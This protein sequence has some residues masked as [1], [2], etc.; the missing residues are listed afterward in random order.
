MHDG[1]R[2]PGSRRALVSAALADGGAAAVIAVA[3]LAPND[4][5]GDLLA[6]LTASRSNALLAAA[7]LEAPAYLVDAL[8]AFKDPVLRRRLVRQAALS[9]EVLTRWLT[10]ANPDQRL[11]AAAA[12]YFRHLTPALVETVLALDASLAEVFAARADLP[13]DV[14]PILMAAFPV[15][16]QWRLARQPQLSAAQV[17]IL[18]DAADEAALAEWVRH[19]AASA[20]LIQR[21]IGAAL[22][23]V[24][25]AVARRPD[26]SLQQQGEL[27]RDDDWSVRARLAALSGLPAD[28]VARLVADEDPRVRRASLL[29]QDP[30]G[31]A[32]RRAARDPECWV[33]EAVGRHPGADAKTLA[34]L[35]ADSIRDVRRSVARHPRCPA[36][37]LL[38]L[39][40]DRESWVRAAVAYR[41]DL[42]RTLVR[43][44]AADVALD[45]QAGV[46]RSPQLP[47]ALQ[48]RWCDHPDA[49]VRRALL[50][51]PKLAPAMVGRLCDD[52]Y[53]LNRVT[54]LRHPRTTQARRWSLRND[55]DPR[56]RSAVYAWFVKNA[57]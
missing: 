34:L 22:P 29:H 10:E 39:S 1:S 43:S 54:A 55:P 41:D 13:G 44:L 9:G 57:A 18:S 37:L 15:R 17:V 53:P 46:A 11:A 45:V 30:G 36:D 25:R 7:S 32:L 12:R 48:R 56:V 26:L 35:A 40:T 33:R 28:L 2:P 47:A 42:A 14:L 49:D 31:E 8:V 4:L 27:A 5:Q 19:P 38:Q 52:P 3:P 6:V 24:R 23:A 16:E 21:G 51:N 20:A 50:S